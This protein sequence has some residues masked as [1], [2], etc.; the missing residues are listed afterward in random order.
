[1]IA[2]STHDEV[3]DQ[4]FGLLD[5]SYEETLMRTGSVAQCA[6]RSL[7]VLLLLCV[8]A[9]MV[10]G[11][12]AQGSVPVPDCPLEIPRIWLA[13]TQH[14]RLLC[15]PEQLA[16]A[17][18]NVREMAWGRKYLESQRGVCERFI[19]M[20]PEDIRALVP[21]PGSGIVF[22][23]TT[24]L[25]P[26]H[27]ERMAWAGWGNPFCVRDA[28]GKL[29]PNDEWPDTGDGVQDPKTGKRY[30]FVAQANGFIIAQLEGNVLPALAD[31]YALTG[32]QEHARTAAILFDA[33]AA[34]NRSTR[35]GPM[36]WSHR[37]G[38][39]NRPGYQVGRALMKY[40][41]ALDLLAP[42]GELERPSF[43]TS[44][45]TIRENLIRNLLWDSG[46]YCLDE[47]LK[48]SQLHNGQAD[49]VRGAAV[50]GILLGVRQFA[51]PMLKGP[52]S[53]D[54]MLAI[55][56]DRNGFYHEVSPSYASYT[57]ELYIMMAELIEAARRIGWEDIPSAYS[58]PGLLLCVAEFFNRREVG[59]HVPQ[60][61]DTG[62]DQTERD[63]LY[64]Q[65]GSGTDRYL[66]SQVTCAW[67]R[68]VRSPDAEDRLRAAQLLR[69]TFGSQM[70]EPL[71]GSRRDWLDCLKWSVY[72]IRPEVV[73]LLRDVEPDAVRFETGSTFY[74]A[75]GLALLRGG[76]GSQR[77][78]AQLFFGPVNNHGHA[79]AL[80]WLFFG[81]GSEWSY[82]TGN[83]RAHYRAG[84]TRYV[85]VGHQAMVVNG[86]SYDPAAGSG[87][88]VSW[89]ETPNVQWALARHPDAYGDQGATRYERLIAQV[90]DP[91]TGEL[92]YWLDVGVVVG[93]DM[94]D[95]SFHTQMRHVKLD[96]PLPKADPNRPS[97]Y[98]DRWFGEMVRDDGRLRG[99][100]YEDKDPYWIPPGNGY[101]FLGNPRETPM[102][103]VVRATFTRPAFARA[104]NGALIA[105]LLGAPGRMLILA[106]SPEA[107]ANSPSVPYL[108]RR[109]AGAGASVFAKVL[110]LVDDPASNHIASLAAIPVGAE[111]ARGAQPG[112]QAWCVTWTDG[113]RD[114]WLFRAMDRPVSCTLAIAGL[115]R[116]ETDANVA[117][118]CFDSGGR[119]SAVHA[120]A[121]TRLTVA[122]KPILEGHATVEGRVV[123]LYTDRDRAAAKVTWTKGVEAARE[124]LP[125]A[126]LLTF[127]PEGQPGTW[128][129]A[130]TGDE[131]VEFEDVKTTLAA[132]VEFTAVKDQPGWYAMRPGVSRFI[133]AWR[134]AMPK[135]AVGKWICCGGRP[136]ARVAEL[137][138]EE[139]ADRLSVRLEASGRPAD[140][141]RRF[142][143][144]I[145]EMGPGDRVIVPI[146][147][148]W[149]AKEQAHDH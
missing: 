89:H 104:F 90:H 124:I 97:L 116:V 131:E 54:T 144:T 149:D 36:D 70:P 68:L 48:G 44:E 19:T 26:V 20:A 122:G 53:L 136:V 28:K 15:G 139:H 98:G 29:Y 143:G 85:S 9:V 130:R 101:G 121:A 95:D 100:E 112:P 111:V 58:N 78:G 73:R 43:S 76:R 23:R 92:G 115:P 137:A 80:T 41:T 47:A 109:D 40:G 133:G 117:V 24:N 103:D 84:W 75:K 57:G 59:G 51:A 7:L 31:V 119:V 123:K 45:K 147:R 42:S 118:V 25:D 79:E 8:G 81:R 65:V 140:L 50:V 99:P 96:L 3:V 61:G 72:H 129:V 13:P 10:P 127:P 120:S 105:D 77:Y 14:P 1:M 83:Y 12:S 138:A 33:I 86:K 125:G 21:P 142:T 56:I 128:R 34:L 52:L 16:V 6:R 35:R 22:L 38:R 146:E 148:H 74:G 49:Y 11:A 102:P 87:H 108:L 114:V 134:R 4:S 141:G 106:D 82:D 39:L 93:G 30:Y 88:L 135:Y 17:R 113:R 32:S 107:F 91:A 37:R 46:A 69:D 67:V 2:T 64:R 110:R 60:L 66:K 55:N 132:N 71:S 145:L 94:R 27:K 126:L 62:T 5:V 63:P 18:R